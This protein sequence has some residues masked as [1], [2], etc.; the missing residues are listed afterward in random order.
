MICTQ[1]RAFKKG[2]LTQVQKVKTL[3]NQSFKLDLRERGFEGGAWWNFVFV[4]V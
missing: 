4:S 3:I 2:S 1:V